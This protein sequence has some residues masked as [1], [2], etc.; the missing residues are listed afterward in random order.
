VRKFNTL[1]LVAL[2]A[3]RSWDGLTLYAVSSDGT[4][5]AFCFDADELEGIAPHS[6][7][8]QYLQKFGFTLPPLPEGWSHTNLQTP[9]SGHRM[10]PPPSPNRSSH[11]PHGLNGFGAPS[12]NTGHEV[13]NTLIAKRN[14]KRRTQQQSLGPRGVSSPAAVYA[15]SSSYHDSLSLVHSRTHYV[16]PTITSNLVPE[17]SQHPTLSHSLDRHSDH[18]P[19]DMVTDVLIDSLGATSSAGTKRKSSVLDMPEDRPSKARTLGGDRVRE[20]NPNIIKEICP[21]INKRTVMPGAFETEKE[22]GF[23]APPVLT[24]LS[25]KVTDAGDDMLECKNAEDGG[26]LL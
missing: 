22:N 21:P 3:L 9:S 14:T 23:S 13:V 5:A 26:E 4:L 16:P 19:P 2:I 20:S 8:Q 24:Y 15:N 18:I 25:L 17:T 6:I 1:Y 10:T 12:A 11:P 7:Q